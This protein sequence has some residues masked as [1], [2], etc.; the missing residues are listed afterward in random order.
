LP[1]DLER[2]RLCRT[3]TLFSMILHLLSTR[4]PVAWPDFAR[5]GTSVESSGRLW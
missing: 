3:Q 2:P 1:D 5:A 4:R